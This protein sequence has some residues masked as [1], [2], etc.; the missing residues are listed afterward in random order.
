M[1]KLP[2]LKSFCVP[3]DRDTQNATASPA[4]IW[5]GAFPARHVVVG[6][7]KL[8]PN[9]ALSKKDLVFIETINGYL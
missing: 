4:A 5:G 2:P 3:A 7:F 6:C 1:P 9:L 8:W